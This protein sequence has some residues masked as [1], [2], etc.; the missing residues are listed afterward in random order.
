MQHYRRLVALLLIALVCRLPVNA[1]SR[2]S[3]Q[4]AQRECSTRLLPLVIRT[5]GQHETAGRM[6]REPHQR[7]AA[8]PHFRIYPE[9]HLPVSRGNTMPVYTTDTGW[10]QEADTESIVTMCYSSPWILADTTAWST[11]LSHIDVLK[12]Y[13][14]DINVRADSAEVRTLLAA[15]RRHDV[16]IAIELGG[17]LDW[18]AAKGALSAEASFQQEYAALRPLIDMLHSIDS[19]RSIDMLDMDGPIRRM[20]F[21]DN[22]QSSYHT[23][24]SAVRELGEVVRMW[25]DAVPGIRINLLSNFPN[26]AWGDTP[27]YFAIDG[28]PNGY[29]HYEDVLDAIANESQRS[30]LYF[31]GLTIDNPYDYA[32]GRAQSNQPALIADVDWMAR[33]RDVAAS[34]RAMG[35]DV[36]M[37]F[38]TNGGRTAETYAAQTLA[39]IDLYH[40]EV[41]IPDGYWIQSWYTL[42]GPWLPESLPNTMTNIVLQTLGKLRLLPNERAL[43]QPDAGRVYHGVQTMTFEGGGNPIA[44]YQSAL[45]DTTIQPAVRGLF[46]SVPGT[47]GP[48]A[49]LRQLRQFFHDADSVG[50]IPELSL[51]LVSDVATDSVIAVSP[52]YDVVIDSIITLSKQYGKAMFLRIGGEFNGVGEG[53]NGGGYHPY[54]YVTMFRK[55]VDMFAARGFRDSVATIWCYY[56]AAANDFDSVDARGARWYPGDDY[57]DWFGLDLFDPEDFDPALP[58]HVRGIITRKGKSERFLAMA[59]DRGKPVYMSET[60]AKGM[61]ISNDPRDGDADWFAWFAKFWDFITLHPEIQGYSY[62]NANWPAHAYPGWGDARIENSSLLSERYRD[63]L[64][65]PRYIHL[66]ISRPVGIEARHPTIL[67]ACDVQITPLPVRD[68][69]T[70]HIHSTNVSRVKISMHDMLGREMAVLYDAVLAAESYTLPFSTGQLPD[71]MYFLRIATDAGVESRAFPLM[72]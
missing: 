1:T 19:S 68:H 30:G 21:P 20:L 53:W 37:I 26:W 3:A 15:L 72:R 36:H 23:L 67:S 2:Y 59:R 66:P 51:F 47:R 69:A 35:M 39:L 65:K 34:A 13:I 25:R 60:S 44:G 5:S 50:F 22:K 58:T 71:G 54:L 57:V 7:L 56:P 14:G 43:L 46:F 11:V 70:L 38:N 52:L 18:H 4:V 64:R 6:T 41:G 45:S 62:I 63:E 24:E 33:V 31:D 10:K 12:I 48:S 32:T 17:L 8:R 42:P 49:S 40:Q 9:C 55:I 29:G 27:A 16:D 61:N 28:E